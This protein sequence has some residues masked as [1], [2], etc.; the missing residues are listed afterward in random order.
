MDAECSFSK[1]HQS[2]CDMLVESVSV[3]PLARVSKLIHKK[4]KRAKKPVK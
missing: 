2:W 3:Q 4:E 1:E